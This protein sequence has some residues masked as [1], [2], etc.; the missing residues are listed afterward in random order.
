VRKGVI[1]AKVIFAAAIPRKEGTA[2]GYARHIGRVG[3]LAVT[4]GVG[5]AMV[6]TPGIAYA[7]PSGSSSSTGGS[8][9]EYVL[10]YEHLVVQEHVLI[11]A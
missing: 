6:T 11:H 3:A 8:F 1:C 5:V 9:H 2:M 7:D 10:S 4:L